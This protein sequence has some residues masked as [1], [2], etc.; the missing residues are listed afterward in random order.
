M[1]S[2]F[3]GLFYTGAAL[4]PSFGG[5][6][7]RASGHNLLSVFYFVVTADILFILITWILLPE[8][9]TPSQM[10]AARQ[11]HY[12]NTRIIGNMEN[13]HGISCM[14]TRVKQWVL[15]IVEPLV[16]FLPTT[17]K[18]NR[19]SSRDWSLTLIIFGCFVAFL[20]VV[21]VLYI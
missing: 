8:S 18:H 19:T 13:N 12:E 9:L 21:S 11:A 5:L 7:L 15:G 14:I 6:L 10:H 16:V 17:L 1:F 3:V 20:V 4:G 2:I